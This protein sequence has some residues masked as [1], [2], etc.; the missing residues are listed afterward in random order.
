MKKMKKQQ[1]RYSYELKK[2]VVEKY[3]QGY[4]MRDL[5]KEYNI[6]SPRVARRWV[7]KVREGGFDAL[8]DK[9]GIKSIG[10]QIRKPSEEETKNEIIE[11]QALEIEYLKKLLELER[12]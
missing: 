7:N 11:R 5:A 2:T 6:S 3:F 9:R 10:K 8:K 4:A 12:M 1:K